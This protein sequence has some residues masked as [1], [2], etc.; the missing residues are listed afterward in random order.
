[1]DKIFV[2]GMKFYAYHGVYKE[3]NTLGQRFEVDVVLEA[4]L[5]K[6]S[7]NDD[8]NYSVNYAEVYEKTKQVV[9]ENTFD[10]VE[11]VAEEIAKTLLGDFAIVQ[12]VTVKVIKPDPPIPGH[13]DSVAIELK[14]SR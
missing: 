8:I 14:R 3:E 5:T 2:N 11:A 13:Y 1:M 10:L 7:L 4:D 12:S 9:E 6:A